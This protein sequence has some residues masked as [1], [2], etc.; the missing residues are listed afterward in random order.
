MHLILTGT[1]GTIG[2]PIL[3]HCLASAQVTRLT[4]LARKSF[5]LPD[6]TKARVIVH[7]DYASYPSA[8]LE[9]L[10]GVDGC[11]WAQGTSQ[12][13]VSEKFVLCCPPI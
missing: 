11:I 5:S 6:S 9:Q 7:E 1:T 13:S 8:L 2:A 12:T 10:S 3:Q 4:I